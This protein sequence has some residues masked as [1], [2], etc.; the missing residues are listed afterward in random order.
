[1]E[2]PDQI[3]INSLNFYINNRN[4]KFLDIRSSDS[5]NGWILNSEKVSGHIK[6]AINFDYDWLKTLEIKNFLKENN[7]IKDDYIVL[8]FTDLNALKVIENALLTLK[9]TN[10]L[11]LNMLSLDN[12]HKEFLE[13]YQNYSKLLPAKII[14]QNSTLLNTFKIF[15]VGFG[16]EEKTS[17]KGHIK[18]SI[19]IDTDELEPPPLWQ[20]AKPELL[21]KT[22]KK[23]G[24]KKSD[25][26][27]ITSWNQMASYRVATILMYIG[28]KDVRVLNGGLSKLETLAYHFEKKSNFPSSL[29]SIDTKIPYNKDLIISTTDLKEKLKTKNF[30]LVDNRTYLEHIGEISGYDYYKK[31]ARIPGAIYGHAGIEGPHSLEYYRNI[32]NTMISKDKILKLW[33]KEGIS[34][35][36]QLAF[37]CGSG[38]RASE[39]YFYAYVLG[40][41]KI[42]IYSDGWIGW[43]RD[44]NNP[45]ETGIP[46][47]NNLLYQKSNL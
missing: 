35:Q 31:K 44:G 37:M 3:N 23:Y 16:S 7:M 43:S 21:Q 13:N 19:Y 2:Y 39:V 29:H 25:S 14:L 22:C 27:L 10:L 9:Y 6:N 36:K 15:H 32:D 11:S 40:I 1:M 46:K 4:F 42:S 45:T 33:S 20:L 17:N 41:P 12:S 8:C 5:F 30:I 26:I 24:I 34:I 38:W 18:G 28:I 47:K